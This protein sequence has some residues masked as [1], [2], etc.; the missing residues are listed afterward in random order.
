MHKVL[1][2]GSGAAGLTAA[3]YAARANL[4]PA[5]VHGVQRGGQLTITTEVENYPGFQHGIMG[6]ALM[7][8]MEAQARR[9]GTQFIE[10]T[11]TKV[12]LSISPFKVWIDDERVELAEALI[13][14]TGASAKLLGLPSEQAFM[15][16]GVSACATCDGFF[17]KEQ[18]ILVVGGGDTAMEEATYLTKFASKVS[19][20]HRREE[21]RASKIM[22]ERARRNPRIAW[23]TNAEVVE[24]QG[25]GDG[26]GRK[27]T[28]ALLRDTVTGETRVEKA[29][30]VFM[31]IGH[32]PN[33]QPFRDW[34]ATDET[35]YIK[36][37]DGTHTSVEG[38]FAAGD[39]QD[40]IYR[41][42]ITAAGSGCMAAIDAERWLEHKRHVEA[43]HGGA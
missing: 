12:D 39:V 41:Q 7:E 23:I 24:I 34:L 2:L 19:I 43:V 4:E 25:E 20:V 36:T 18:E 21:F 26:L 1:I 5:L 22:L 38:V 13:V 37:H 10:G 6:P 31:A 16:F 29:G 35:G 17:F 11:V 9:F 28:G 8:E 27:V 33:S 30:G 42:A 15:G 3:I 14:A 40:K 32:Q